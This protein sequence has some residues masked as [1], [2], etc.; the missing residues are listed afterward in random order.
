[1]KKQKSPKVVE[2]I[3]EAMAPYYDF[4]YGKLLFNEGREVSIELLDLKSGDRILEVGVGTGLTLPLYPLNCK[5]VGV[6]LSENMLKEAEKLI[7]KKKLRNFEVKKMDATKLEFKDSSF[8]AVLGNLFISATTYPENALREM[9]R[10]CKPK[11]MI[12]L[13]N[14]FLSENPWVARAETAFN[15]IAEKIGYKSNLEMNNLLASVGLKPKT[16]KKVNLFNLWTAV[17]MENNK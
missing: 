3:Y 14:H 12:V 17:S 16:I 4:I 8:D 7:K 1:M 6:D 11:G 9:I 10:V 15:P 5:V 2:R 13:M